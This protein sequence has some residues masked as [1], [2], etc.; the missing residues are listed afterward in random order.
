[1]QMDIICQHFQGLPSLHL[2]QVC[3]QKKE[4]MTFRDEKGVSGDASLLIFKSGNIFMEGDVSD[5][6]PP[7]KL[8]LSIFSA[9]L[10]ICIISEMSYGFAEH[11]FEKKTDQCLL[12]KIFEEN[13]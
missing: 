8:F 2:R 1:M 13:F 9:Y 3:G 6:W 10:D 7:E 5:F 11:I 4:Y 12:I